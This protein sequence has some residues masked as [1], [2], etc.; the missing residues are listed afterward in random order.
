MSSNRKQIRWFRHNWAFIQMLR[1]IVLISCL[2]RF[3]WVIIIV[4]FRHFCSV[5]SRKFWNKKPLKR[6][7]YIIYWSQSLSRICHGCVALLFGLWS[8]PS[9]A[10]VFQGVHTIWKK[11][12]EIATEN[13]ANGMLRTIYK[14]LI[15]SRFHNSPF[16]DS[17]PNGC[18][19]SAV[20]TVNWSIAYHNAF[21]TSTEFFCQ[22]VS[23]PRVVTQRASP[24]E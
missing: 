1:F 24:A 17:N 18:G 5:T 8:S 3:C 10:A 20:N 11:V 15:P 19:N 2:N 12:S 9:F 13:W 6:S 23:T 21:D 16:L 22:M 4:L 7:H 14:F